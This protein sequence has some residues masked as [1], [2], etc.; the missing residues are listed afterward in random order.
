M[1]IFGDLDTIW[2][3]LIPDLKVLLFETFLI[4]K[5][6]WKHFTLK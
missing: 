2:N 6:F 5:I 3:F 4:L 1:C